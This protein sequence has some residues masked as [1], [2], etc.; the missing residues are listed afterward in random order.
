MAADPGMVGHNCPCKR[1]SGNRVL[2]ALVQMAWRHMQQTAT[3]GAPAE[4]PV[5]M[6]T[7]RSLDW[8]SKPQHAGRAMYRSGQTSAVIR[9]L[10]SW[11]CPTNA[12]LPDACC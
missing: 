2:T 5:R 1:T 6:I 8:Q 3:C 9:D 11:S 7:L 10:P 4:R 12:T